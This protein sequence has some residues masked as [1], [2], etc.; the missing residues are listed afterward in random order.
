M[1]FSKEELLKEVSDSNDEYSFFN[2]A[3]LKL[4]L[5]TYGGKFKNDKQSNLFRK[6]G[7]L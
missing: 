2:T 1:V 6:K 4:L 7:S 3:S 5:D